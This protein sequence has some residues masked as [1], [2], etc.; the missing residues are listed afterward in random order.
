MKSIQDR[1]EVDGNRRGRAACRV[2]RDQRNTCWR[3]VEMA[4]A[5]LGV[6][7]RVVISIEK[8]LPVQIKVQLPFYVGNITLQLEKVQ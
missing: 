4:L 6:R 7:A 5:E 1:G 2:P 3:V 8:R